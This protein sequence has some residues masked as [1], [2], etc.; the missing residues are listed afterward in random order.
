MPI[1]LLVLFILITLPVTIPIAAV[2]HVR[3]GRRMQRRP[4]RLDANAAAR[5]WALLRFVA[6]TRNGQNEQQSGGADGRSSD[7]A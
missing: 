1:P 2:L 4:S 3:N 5:P 7:I 6:L